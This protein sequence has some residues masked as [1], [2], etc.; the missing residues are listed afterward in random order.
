MPT[1]TVLPHEKYCPEGKTFS[2]DKGTLL[3][4]ALLAAGIPIPHSC[5]KQG[6]CAS[7]HVYV[8]HGAP[9]LAKASKTEEATLD[10]AWGLS[11]DSR[12]S[13]QVTIGSENLTIEI[14]KYHGSRE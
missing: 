2:T 5:E 13:C 8:Q 1:I 9:S 10:F 14:P 7:C 11:L 6:T 4:D 3:I 12:L